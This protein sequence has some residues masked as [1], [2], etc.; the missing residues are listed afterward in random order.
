KK[1]NMDEY[2]ADLKISTVEI[3]NSTPKKRQI[4]K[5]ILNSG[6]ITRHENVFLTMVQNRAK[7]YKIR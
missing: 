2:L 1:F 6:E 7:I 5:D 4:T 3:L